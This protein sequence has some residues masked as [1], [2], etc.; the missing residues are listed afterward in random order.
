MILVA[1]AASLGPQ[2]QARSESDPIYHKNL[3][4]GTVDV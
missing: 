4:S 2:F 1:S 3:D